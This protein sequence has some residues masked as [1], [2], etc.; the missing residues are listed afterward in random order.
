[1]NLFAHGH[2]ENRTATYN[3]MDATDMLGSK[4]KKIEEVCTREG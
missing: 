3:P 2:G 1:M 4:G